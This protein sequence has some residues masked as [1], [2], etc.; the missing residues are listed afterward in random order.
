M[1][2]PLLTVQKLAEWIGETPKAIYDRDIAAI[3][4]RCR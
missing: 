1:P 2:E 4:G 3:Q